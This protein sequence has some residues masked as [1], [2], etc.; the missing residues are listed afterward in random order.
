VKTLVIASIAL[1]AP[2]GMGAQAPARKNP[3]QL[4]AAEVEKLETTLKANPRDLAARGTLLEYYFVARIDPAV[5]VPARR[6]HILWVI[7]N[8][9]DENIAYGPVMTIDAAGH[10][11]ADPQGF[12]LASDA[13]R[14]QSAKPDAKA[15]TLANASYFFKTNDKP[16]T[17]SLL[18]RALAMDNGN[19]EIAA[20]LGDEYA[21]VILGVTMINRSDYPVQSDPAL[22]ESALAEQS[23]AELLA[24]TNPYTVAKAGYQILWQGS[25]LYFS[26]GLPFDPEPLAKTVLD[27]AVSLAPADRDVAALRAEYDK[28]RLE[29]QRILN[30]AAPRAGNSAPP[31]AQVARK[32][33]T[34]TPAAAP[35][36]GT[37]TPINT[38]APAPAPPAQ[39]EVDAADLRT[40]TAGMTR[41]EVLKLGAPS[42]RITM[43][44]DSHLIEVYQYSAK[45]QRVGTVRLRDGVV[46][47]VQVP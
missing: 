25:I 28:F 33:A 20:R 42:G 5:A 18:R 14:A 24:A 23:R 32:D 38:T 7:E 13:W 41:E 8:A 34:Q 44:E 22:A 36:A 29:R 12:R 11:L 2:L 16:Y 46:F 40:V 27:R 1:A 19:K 45:G 37:A 39:P 17:I 43:E 15:M 21:L 26:Q 4:S 31:R 6:R 35:A 10:F 3:A 30:G 47:S 9:P